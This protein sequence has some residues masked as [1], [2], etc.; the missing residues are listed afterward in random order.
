MKI[1]YNGVILLLII[2]MSLVIIPHTFA[3][4]NVT[5]DDMLSD[6]SYDFY[7]DSN[8][9]HDHGDGSISNPYKTLKDERILDNSRIHL[10]NGEYD[11]S[12]LKTHT[13]IS[14]YGE[15]ALKTI[16]KGND[17]TLVVNSNIV[18]KDISLL[19]IS[20][21][22]Q[23]D[24]I[25]SNTIFAN[26]TATK[27]GSYS[28]SFGGA[29]YSS[30]PSYNV[31]LTN[32]TFINN[33]ADYGGA[34]YSIGGILQV[35]E[36]NF[37]N[38]TAYRFGGAIAYNANGLKGNV[39]LEKS[40]FLNNSAIK[41]AGGAIYLK[42]STLNAKD[43]N[44]SSSKATFG[45]ALTLIESNSNLN[46]IY[47]FNN[48]AKYEGG[49]VYQIYGNITL[50]NSKFI[51]NSARNGGGLLIDGVEY[52][53]VLDNTFTNNKADY[54]GGAFLSILINHT[55]INRN[56][57]LNNSAAYFNDYYDA[58]LKIRLYLN[59]NYSLYK[60]NASY[61]VLPSYYSSKDLG[62]VTPV[63]D[64]MDGG[65]CWSFSILATL[66]SCILKASGV[67]LDLSEENMKNL[68][69]KYSD[70]GWLVEPNTGGYLDMGVGYLT[71]WF[72]P[73]LDRDDLYDAKSAISPLLS[74]IAYV[75]NIVY[76]SRNSFTD[77]YE[78]KK[79]IRDY[80]AVCSGIYMTAYYNS[81]VDAYVQYYKGSAFSDHA[82]VLV[83]WDDDFY[84]PNAPGRGAWIA[85]NSWGN[86]WGN[87][88]YFYVSY[89]DTSCLKI[90]DNSTAFTF[91]LDDT[92]KYD[93][94][95]QY[96]IAK[97]DYFYNTASTVWYKNLFTS[98]DSEYLTAVSTYFVK[99][100][101]WDLSIYVNGALKAVKSGF[102]KA[103]YTTI[104]LDDFISLNKGDVF[105][106]IFKIN[107][108]GD[109]GV[110]ISEK[111]SLN[112]E[113]YYN[114]I[115]FLSY[116]GVNWK[117]LY[118]LKGE[119]P[120]HT[121]LSQVAC[122]KAF[123]ILNPINTT[124]KLILDNKDHSKAD[125]IASVYNQYGYLIEHGNIEFTIQNKTYVY[126]ISNS[127][128]KIPINLVNDNITAKFSAVGHNP[129]NITIEIANPLV[130]TN[131]S[132]NISGKY[133]PINI[134]A[135]VMDLNNNPV[136][137]GF[138]V[139][140]VENKNYTVEVKN[141]IAVLENIYLIP[142]N[143]SVSA[144]YNDLFY[145]ELSYAN[146][147]FELLKIDTK[148]NLTVIS[149]GANNPVN[150]TAVIVD[151]NN[152]PVKV[153]NVRFNFSGDCVHTNVI[154]GT[155]KFN[156]IFT[157][158]GLNTIEAVYL[159][160]YLYNP[161]NSSKSLN[162]SK[163][164][165]NLTFSINIYEN[166]AILTTSIPNCALEYN[167]ILNFNNKNTTY[168]SNY[169]I[170][171][172]NLN[173]LEKG[174]YAYSIKLVSSI[175]NASDIIG[176]FDIVHVDTKIEASDKSLFYGGVYS[177]ILKDKNG[178]IIPDRDLYLVFGSKT[179][180]SR[181]NAEGVAFFNVK[182]QNGK[183]YTRVSFIGDDEYIRY[184]LN[185]NIEVK[186]TIVTS[187]NVFAYNSPYKVTLL[188]SNGNILTNKKATILLGGVLYSLT[189]DNNGLISV[190]VKLNSGNYDVIITNEETGEVKTH[191][192]NVVNRI[193]KNS[194]LKMYYG[195]GKYYSV[196][197]CDDNGKYVSGLDVTFKINGQN[198]VVKTDSKGYASLKI[199]LKPGTYK[200]TAEYK[201]FKV[202]NKI[203]VKTILITKNIKVK[204][205]KT[206]NF[207][208]KL[209]KSNGKKLKNKVVKFKFKGKVYK[210]KTNKK[211][212]AILKLKNPY[213]AG[214]YIIYTKY[215]KLKNK[216]KIII[217]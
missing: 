155:A 164:N 170:V 205:S 91:I 70:Y 37:I 35:V 201:G 33:N 197:V 50:S 160:D 176:S 80:G 14:F 18:L 217:K 40:K 206:I 188:D 108:I 87:D 186:S 148:M 34:I 107:Q 51:D 79:A 115:S 36:C 62:Y 22:N 194:N 179:Y 116:D 25:A 196:R 104:Q 96:D 149:N 97:T 182:L 146:K 65:N 203:V 123:T 61:D 102:S 7:F 151:I 130:K 100:T 114:G 111:M 159:E 94:N 76:V 216:N 55:N 209:L 68:A 6:D 213:K 208:A 13:N 39:K 189:S 136:K 47:L 88:G 90:G 77:N 26:S 67:N 192:I 56:N 190:N 154:N 29:I 58:E 32:C 38:N 172:M 191:K 161:S 117:D 44:I 125:L 69:S 215:G 207:K 95:Y 202:S 12:Q 9:A 174:S 64:Q 178:N 83:G 212:L 210:I 85:K 1:K 30:S 173:N 200:I 99:N 214:K 150:V 153:G 53:N 3:A 193:T 66:E 15:D 17:A 4:C 81:K 78:V 113:Y 184:S 49:A 181:T 41:N 143:L 28:D 198:H 11:Y 19:R 145:Y 46:N 167:V 185:V 163:M 27:T 42:H 24:L 93:K 89:Y 92:I 138:V 122:I 5:S 52:A 75:Q 142:D 152:N 131:I 120:D 171:E 141:G 101:N 63:K 112:K 105:E 106:V 118:T 195:A 211:G 8:A 72:G 135:Y 2:F 59:D 124:I 54:Y 180:K 71:G 165:I 119:Y 82:V 158:T 147:S 48:S 57:Y 23:G 121:Y 60:Y 144:Y 43:L 175:Y 199:N 20:I 183:Y 73:V 128:V 204:K 162:V 109:A 187:S 110:P 177:A 127:H 45:A 84:I 140:N 126:A 156:Y 129:S 133:N 74:S 157:K 166:N 16:I 137:T 86:N 31:Y 132:I 168:K 139:F 98:T 103:S 134:T 21:F 10:A 169:G